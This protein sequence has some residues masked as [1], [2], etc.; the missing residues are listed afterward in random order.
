MSRSYK[1]AIKES[2]K[3]I[4]KT[5]DKVSSKLE[6]LDILPSGRMAELLEKKLLEGRF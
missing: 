6:I 5:D 3:K 4:L 2:I 1:V